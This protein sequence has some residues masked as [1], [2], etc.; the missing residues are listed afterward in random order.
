MNA[1]HHIPPCQPGGEED[2]SVC[3]AR[4]SGGPYRRSVLEV[5]ILTSL[6]ASDSHGYDLM[7]RIRSLAGDQVCV[8]PGSVYRL[9]RAM[10]VQGFVESA[11]QTAESGPSRRVY[12]I[13]GEGIEAL[14][15]MAASLSGRAAALQNLSEHACE[16]A[17][18]SR[19]TGVHAVEQKS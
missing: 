17:A 10:E 12:T 8:D 19:K 5:A 15:Q 9:L 1:E 16:A 18:R 14:E 13:A 4:L 6:A 3:G 2:G 7:D 11:W